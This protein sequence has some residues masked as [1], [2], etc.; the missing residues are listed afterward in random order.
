[1]IYFIADDGWGEGSCVKIGHTKNSGQQRLYDLQVGNPKELE[2]VWEVSGGL[3]LE[4]MLH[5]LF[6]DF[7]IR[8]EWF[9]YTEEFK[10][11]WFNLVDERERIVERIKACKEERS[12]KFKGQ[13]YD[14]MLCRWIF[15]RL[16]GSI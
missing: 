9:H 5:E 1:M 11:L 12:D 4:A 10:E 6:A 7:Y 15:D 3:A 8:G 14:S 2:L 13:Y 16:E